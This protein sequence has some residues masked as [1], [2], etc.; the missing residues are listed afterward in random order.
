MPGFAV[1]PLLQAAPDLPGQ[2]ATTQVVNE[3]GPERHHVGTRQPNRRKE[4]AHGG[5]VPRIRKPAGLAHK[6]RP[7]V[8]SAPPDAHQTHESVQKAKVHA[9]EHPEHASVR[10]RGHIAEGL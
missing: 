7:I 5:P 8:H 3:Q 10:V 2:K 4:S 6:G 9:R 1:R